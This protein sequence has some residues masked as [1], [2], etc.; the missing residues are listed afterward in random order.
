MISSPFK[1]SPSP[2]TILILNPHYI[3]DLS[4][5]GNCFNFLN[6]SNY[7]KIHGIFH[8]QPTLAWLLCLATASCGCECNFNWFDGVFAMLNPICHNSQ[9]KCLCLGNCL[10]TAMSILHHPWK[11]NNFGNPSA[12]HLLFCCNSKFHYLLLLSNVT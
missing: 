7:L 8:R 10:L 11:F 2:R 4:A 12:I 9:C 5:Y 1:L 6:F 3:P